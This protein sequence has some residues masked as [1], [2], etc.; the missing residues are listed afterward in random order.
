MAAISDDDDSAS[1]T[2]PAPACPAGT[3]ASRCPAATSL[4]WSGI[5]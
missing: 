3:N 1:P 4:D 2:T 5:C